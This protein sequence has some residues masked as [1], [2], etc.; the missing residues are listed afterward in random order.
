MGTG[1]YW[2]EACLVGTGPDVVRVP[3]LLPRVEGTNRMDQVDQAVWVC[4]NFPWVG[5]NC[6]QADS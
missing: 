3:F 1:L 5:K 6:R 4:H 2:K